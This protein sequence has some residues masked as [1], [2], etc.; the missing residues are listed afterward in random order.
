MCYV[1]SLKKR[2][3]AF[4]S[5]IPLGNKLLWYV[6]FRNFYL[7]YGI[8][9]T[10]ALF[11]LYYK[12][13]VWGNSQSVSGVGS[14]IEYTN[15]IRN[16][17]PV[18]IRDLGIHRILDAPCGDYNWFRL[19]ELPKNVLYTGGDIVKSLIIENQKKYGNVNTV[20]FV[21]NIIKD[22]LPEAD[23]WLCRDALIHFSNK[24]IFLTIHNFLKSNIPYL[25]T[26]SYATCAKN[27][28]IPT[29]SHRLLNLE[30][31]PFNFCKP[32]LY[33]ND[34]IKGFPVRKLCL[35]NKQMLLECL[36]CNKQF[37]ELA[38]K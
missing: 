25:L 26:T 29:G 16:K 7:R 5:L 3:K 23:L 17:I 30:L 22:K 33:I 21:T 13:N 2:L 24:D 31:P 12:K 10:D 36:V 14:T 35:W 38:N 20:F 11:N 15:N 18:L 27:E 32:I 1:G 37:K 8:K 9:S 4:L 34:W 28:D 6:S 19:I